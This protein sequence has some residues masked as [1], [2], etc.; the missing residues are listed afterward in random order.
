MN[1]M[2]IGSIL[3]KHRLKESRLFRMELYSFRM[4]LFMSAVVL[5][6]NI[7]FLLKL[8][9]INLLH[10][11]SIRRT[12]YS[13]SASRQPG[14]KSWRNFLFTHSMM[15]QNNNPVRGAF[16]LLLIMN[17]KFQLRK[18]PTWQLPRKLSNIMSTYEHMS[19]FML[20]WT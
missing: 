20:A 7:L 19:A 17:D 1:R 10:S 12:S 14:R 16:T 5:I 13:P 4:A 9:L 15:M 11:Y 2:I 8:V 3:Y 6:F 18:Y